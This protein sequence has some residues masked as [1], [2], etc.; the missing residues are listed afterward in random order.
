MTERIE[1]TDWL[2]RRGGRSTR[3][4]YASVQTDSKFDIYVTIF[5]EVDDRIPVGAVQIENDNGLLMLRTWEGDMETD[6]VIDKDITIDRSQL[7]WCFKCGDDFSIHQ[8]DGSCVKD[9]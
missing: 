4:F 2:L 6:P 5:D 8:D 9:E 1:L 3:K 7:R